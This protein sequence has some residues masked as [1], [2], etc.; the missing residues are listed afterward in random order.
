MS[1]K[2]KIVIVDDNPSNLAVFHKTLKD[3]YEVHPVSSASKMFEVLANKVPDLIL[4]D[5]LMPET[6]GYEAM[7]MLK[8]D[9]RYKEIP[10]IFISALDDAESEMIGLDLGAVDYIHK[11]VDTA[12][13]FKRVKTHLSIIQGKNELLALNKSI[14]NL[15]ESKINEAKVQEGRLE[16]VIKNLLLKDELLARMGHE[17]RDPLNNIIEFIES[18]IK[19]ADID[20]IKHHLRK[21]DIE[22]RLILEIIDDTLDI[23]G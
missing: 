4:L 3:L 7:Y 19:E 2:K 18:A 9:E 21:A 16:E 8:D 6:N 15:L 14:E 5:V 20:E 11:P 1:K 10:V 22:T 17:L 12:L 23:P 13:L